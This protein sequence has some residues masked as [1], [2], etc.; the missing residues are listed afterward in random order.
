MVASKVAV[1]DERGIMLLQ[2]GIL[3]S[4]VLWFRNWNTQTTQPWMHL[5]HLDSCKTECH[6][7]RQFEFFQAASSIKKAFSFAG[8]NLRLT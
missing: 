2:R 3:R 5:V 4:S 1:M 6:S 7:A 8:T